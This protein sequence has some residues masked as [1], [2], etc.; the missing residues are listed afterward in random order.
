MTKFHFSFGISLKTR[1]CVVGSKMLVHAA[2][3]ILPSINVQKFVEKYAIAE[4]IMKEVNV[5][6]RIRFNLT[7]LWYMHWKAL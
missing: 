5:T 2:S 3:R 7:C 4:P 1:V 6:A